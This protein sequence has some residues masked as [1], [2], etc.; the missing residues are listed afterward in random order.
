MHYYDALS[1]IPGQLCQEYKNS[2][3]GNYARGMTKGDHGHDFGFLLMAP[4]K[5]I[6]WF[7]PESI[8]WAPPSKSDTF[9]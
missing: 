2:A 7:S 5:R 1:G 3:D 4:Q 6:T 9:C 8:F